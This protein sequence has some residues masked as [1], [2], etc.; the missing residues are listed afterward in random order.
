[1]RHRNEKAKCNMKIPY[2]KSYIEL[3]EYN[4]NNKTIVEKLYESRIKNLFNMVCEIYGNEDIFT[5]RTSNL[6]T[7]LLKGKLLTINNHPISYLETGKLNN[8][9]RNIIKSYGIEYID[10]EL[11][12]KE[13]K[14]EGNYKIII[15]TIKSNYIN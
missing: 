11:I 7:Q 8:I 10:Y 14:Y 1:M 6:G 13:G 9:S 4:E 3:M 12:H 5:W 15:I 2:I